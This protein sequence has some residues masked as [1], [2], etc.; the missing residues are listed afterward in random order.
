MTTAY[1]SA[2]AQ[3]QSSPRRWLITGAAGFIGSHLLE[4]LLKLDQ[5]VVGLD[6]FATGKQSNLD[7]VCVLVTP[8][9]W[10]RF[11]FIEAD[12]GEQTACE[13]A[14]RGVDYVLHQAALGSVPLSMEHPDRTHHSN[15]TGFLNLL[16]AARDAAVKRFVYASSCAV[17]GDDPSLPKTEDRVGR[18]LSPYAASK[19]MNELYADVFGR[20]FGFASI[21]LRYFNVFGPRQDPEGAYAAVIPKWIAALIRREPVFINGDG[22]TSRDFCYIENVV[23]ANLL[24]ATTSH[25]VAVNQVYNIAV[26]DRTTLNQLYDLLTRLMQRLDP[27]LPDCRPEYRDFR[28]GDVRHS[29]AD[30]RKAQRLLGYELAIRI[31]QGL[32]TT[33]DWFVSNPC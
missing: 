30:V 19:V 1:E 8:A 10:S 18:P 25:A 24:A 5:C 4:A 23:R 32:E 27:E 31:E 13:R 28:P 29:L 33:V 20:A 2:R 21:G 3:L 12:I 14:C 17:Y 9:Q 26:G 6:N 16:M 11:Q 7:Q 22:K 15:V